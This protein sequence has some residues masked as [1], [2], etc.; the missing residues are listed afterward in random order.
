MTQGLQISGM[1]LGG[2]VGR[3]EV[4]DDGLDPAVGRTGGD[5]AFQAVGGP[6]EAQHQGQV[7]PRRKADRADSLGVDL[8]FLGV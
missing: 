6:R 3:T 1:S 5:I 8:V 4:I 7:A 2:Q